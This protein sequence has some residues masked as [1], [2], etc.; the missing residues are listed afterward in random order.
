MLVDSLTQKNTA[1]FQ[2]G[3]GVMELLSRWQQKNHLTHHKRGNIFC[4]VGR[5]TML[6]DVRT[7]Y[8]NYVNSTWLK[9]YLTTEHF[10]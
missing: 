6:T 9:T 10:F 1:L 3:V 4:K 8:R 7:W 2:L 5:T